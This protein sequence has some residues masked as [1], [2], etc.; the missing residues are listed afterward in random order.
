MTLTQVMKAAKVPLLSASVCLIR[1]K[2]WARDEAWY[3]VNGRFG[4]EVETSEA[5]PRICLANLTARD[6]EI[7]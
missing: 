1:R 3:V 4:L 6:W 5:R 7:V 2:V